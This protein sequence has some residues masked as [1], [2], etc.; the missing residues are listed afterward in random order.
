MSILHYRFYTKNILS[1]NNLHL[2]NCPLHV[3]ILFYLMLTKTHS[4]GNRTEGGAIRCVIL[5][6]IKKI[7]RLHSRS[8]N[9]LITRVITDRIG[10]H[11]VLSPISALIIT[12]T[13]FMIFKALSFLNQNTRNL[14]I[15]FAG[16]EK[17]WCILSIYL[18]MMRSLLFKAEI[19]GVY[20]QSDLRILSYNHVLVK[21][22]WS[23]C[24]ECGTKKKSE[25]LTGSNL[26]PPKHGGS[27]H[28][29]QRK[30]CPITHPG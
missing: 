9:C 22:K 20:C 14:K 26:W 17:W 2:N 30:W 13:K 16:S 7:G 24:H 5:Q 23:A 29:V 27:I 3:Y 21:M 18:G 15:F 11:K 6:V 4:N 25:S 12:L 10:R 28:S 8:L 19:R 1:F